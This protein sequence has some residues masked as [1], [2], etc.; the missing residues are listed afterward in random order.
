ML[1]QPTAKTP[2]PAQAV[3]AERAGTLFGLGASM[4]VAAAYA[5]AL[6][7]LSLGAA[8]IHFAVA[9]EHFQEWWAFGVFFVA[10]GWFEAVWA[11]AYALTQTRGLAWLAIIACLATV[12]IWAASRTVGLPFGPD[13]G[14]AEAI[15]LPDI[16]AGVFELLLAVGLLVSARIVRYPASWPRSFQA[17]TVVV[18]TSAVAV[19]VGLIS[20]AGIAAGMS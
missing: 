1:N 18:A 16:A 6:A 14:E 11:M 9:P 13:P 19:V 2:G 5:P 10:I 17:R 15:G 12:A 20:L 7:I 3:R 8:A 4:G